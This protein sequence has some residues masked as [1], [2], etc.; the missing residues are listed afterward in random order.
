M[1]HQLCHFEIPADDVARAREFYKNL[2]GWQISEV[3][4]GYHLI[5]TGENEVPGGMMKRV[6]PQQ[7]PTVYFEVES[8]DDYIRRIQELGGKIIVP[9]T[10]VPTMGYFAHAMDTEGNVFAIWRADSQAK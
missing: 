1:P 4:G 6:V 5:Q 3:E 8:A 7:Q 9:K 2:F 10:P